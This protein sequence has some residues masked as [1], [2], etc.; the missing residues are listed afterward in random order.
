MECSSIKI[1][2]R[3]YDLH[4]I[5]SISGNRSML[6]YICLHRSYS[7]V[8]VGI[9]QVD[10]VV[11]TVSVSIER[12]HLIKASQPRILLQEPA[13]R[14][15]IPPHAHLLQPARQ[16]LVPIAPRAVP[17][18]GLPRTRN[19]VAE[20]IRYRR[21]RVRTRRAAGRCQVATQVPVLVFRP[22]VACLLIHRPTVAV[23]YPLQRVA[24]ALPSALRYQ[25]PS[26]IA[27]PFPTVPC[28]SVRRTRFRLQPFCR[29]S[30]DDLVLAPDFAGRIYIIAQDF[31]IVEGGQG[32]WGKFRS[33]LEVSGMWERAIS[34]FA[35]TSA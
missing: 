21:R 30:I 28:A 17:V 29:P 27:I 22:R 32:N 9:D 31:T 2:T 35:L 11:G 7:T 3:F 34:A 19:R 16:R 18:V 20:G 33:P 5:R 26:M 24:T 8:S 12:Q 14:R 25:I 15:V 13:D 10:G 6:F 4:L 1:F 23:V